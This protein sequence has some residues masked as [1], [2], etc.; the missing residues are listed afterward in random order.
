L[1]E[2]DQAF[3]TESQARLDKG[4]AQYGSTKFLSVDTIE[5]AMAEVVDLGNYA[6]F[7]YIKL[8]ILRQS[9]A[10]VTAQHPATDAKGFIPMKEFMQGE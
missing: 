8:F 2:A 6:R 1:Q 4:E 7:T 10:R 3:L 5:E 9:I